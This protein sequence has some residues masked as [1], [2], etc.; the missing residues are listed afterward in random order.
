[1]GQ[2]RGTIPLRGIGR[3]GEEL[4]WMIAV[5]LLLGLEF[6]AFLRTQARFFAYGRCYWTVLG[7]KKF[8]CATPN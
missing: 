6:L 1:M 5:S 3:R 4:L 8:L 2:D 7:S